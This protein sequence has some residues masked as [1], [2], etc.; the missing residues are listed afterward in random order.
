MNEVENPKD[1]KRQDFV[2]RRHV[3]ATTVKIYCV[4]M[5]FAI[6]IFFLLENTELV[7]YFGCCF[8]V[9]CD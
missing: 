8:V 6:Y 9:N 3:L 7:P 5:P 1:R 2:V 4:K